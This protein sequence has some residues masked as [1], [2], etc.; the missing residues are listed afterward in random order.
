MLFS[1]GVFKVSKVLYIVAEILSRHFLRK[2]KDFYGLYNQG[3][4][5]AVVTGGSDGIGEEFCYELARLGFNICII[6]RNEDKIKQKL[7]EVKK[8]L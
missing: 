7:E 3:D 2:R 4:S 6:A 8:K 1:I 5:W